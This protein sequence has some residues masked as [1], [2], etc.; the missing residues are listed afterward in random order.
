M[1]LLLV[2]T[3]LISSICLSICDTDA[4]FESPDSFESEQ[5]SIETSNAA[6]DVQREKYVKPIPV[7]DYVFLETFDSDPIGSKWMK[8]KA[9]KDDVDE[10]IAKYDGQWA[11]ESSLDSVLE[12]DKGLVLKS[13]AKHHAIS[14][15]LLRPFRF[16]QGKT[17]VIQYEV[18]F[19]NALECGGAYAKL[20]SDE[21][22]LSLDN[23]FDKTSF[24]IM[25][26]PDRCGSENKYH[27][28]IRFKNPITGSYEEKHA[29]PSEVPAN[30]FSDGKSHLYTLVV[31]PDNTFKMLIDQNVVNSGSLLTDLNPSIVPS[32]EIVDPNDQKPESWDERE[33]IP[34]PD[35]TKPEDWDESEPKQIVDTN[36]VKPDGWLDNELDMIPEPE[37]VKPEDWDADTDGE[38][39]APKI[40]NPVCKEAPG[41]GVW[42]PPMIDNPKYKGKWKAPMIENS[43]YQGKWE[44]RKI[45]N[46]EYFEETNPFSKLTSF[47]AIGLELWSMTDNIYFDNFIITDDENVASRFATDSWVIRNRLENANIKSNESFFNALVNATREKPWLW[48][49]YVIVVL[50]PIVLIAVFCFGKSAS[51]VDPGIAKKTDTET[52]D[53][54][55]ETNQEENSA[56]NDEQEEA[57]EAE[58]TDNQKAP[59]SK[60]DL[61]EDEAQPEEEEAPVE[62]KKSPARRRTARKD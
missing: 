28:I 7:G 26:G 19:Q 21:P 9:K 35:A 44:P 1:K 29:K 15:R 40:E 47:S 10:S 61:E 55:E 49:L 45:S 4:D 54:Q 18:K 5:E 30:I 12:G 8:S 31:N 51:K 42:H 43:N 37:A 52:K 58:D 2:L 33:K 34:D 57:E 39:E 13:K 56:E 62:N 59:V 27:F 36:A 22:D 60:S 16:D 38:W 17:L 41:C 46:P 20:L 11:V 53:D 25:F 14:A 3:L 23:F 48:G 24:S 50:V 32:K 6:Q